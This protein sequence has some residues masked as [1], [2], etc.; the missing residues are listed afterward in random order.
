MNR[1]APELLRAPSWRHENKTIQNN[2]PTFGKKLIKVHKRC[3]FHTRCKVKN[4]ET[5]GLSLRPKPDW[6]AYRP[7]LLSSFGL[8]A[9]A[10]QASQLRAPDL[11]LLNDGPSEPCY[12]SAV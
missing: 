2:R 9:L 6:G 7:S 12:A 4:I 5:L 1:G 10:H 3:D 8:R 11:I